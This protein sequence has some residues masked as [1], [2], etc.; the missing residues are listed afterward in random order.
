M[1]NIIHWNKFKKQWTS[2]IYK[3]CIQAPT[4][5]VCGHWYTE[6]KP[7]KK[8]NPRGWIVTDDKNVIINPDFFLLKD[9][10]I[11]G[12]LIYDKENISFNYTEGGYLLF[13]DKGCFILEQA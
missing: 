9:F 1:K 8:S 13:N 3:G 7:D 5:L 2:H 12:K 11:L 10:R 4:I 6:T